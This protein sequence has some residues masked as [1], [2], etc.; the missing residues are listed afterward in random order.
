M[1]MRK[2]LVPIAIGFALAAAAACSESA[3][4][5]IAAPD[6][7]SASQNPYTGPGAGENKVSICHAAG[8]VGTTHYVLI[9]VGAP[10]Q[11]AHI[12]DHGT[13]TAGHEED[14][15]ASSDEK[16]AGTCSGK[17]SGGTITKTLVGVMT[18]NAAGQMIADPTWTGGQVTVPAG[19]TRWLEYQLSYSLPSG[20]TGTVT[21]NESAV[22]NTMGATDVNQTGSGKITCS[23]NFGGATPGGLMSGGIVSW[24]GLSANGSIQVPIDISGGGVL[25]GHRTFTNTATLVMS[26]GTSTSASTSTVINFLGSNGQSCP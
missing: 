22:C 9:T 4:S 21:E 5:R 23:I 19:Q 6:Q 1:T 24:S 13:P 17:S 26:N 11:Y 10:A 25:C 3:T 12:D 8:R 20:I 15:Y 18:L 14:Y 7:L 16:H 2:P